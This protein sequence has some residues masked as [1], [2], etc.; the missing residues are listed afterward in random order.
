MGEN[1]KKMV[2]SLVSQ[3]VYTENVHKK[4]MRGVV[5]N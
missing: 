5:E 1:T 3:K 2:R 4:R